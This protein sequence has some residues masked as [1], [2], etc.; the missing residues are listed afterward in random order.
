MTKTRL[1]EF[2]RRRRH[3]QLPCAGG[4]QGMLI[5]R[6]LSIPSLGSHVVSWNETDPRLVSTAP[7]PTQHPLGSTGSPNSP[8]RAL[9]QDSRSAKGRSRQQAQPWVTVT[10]SDS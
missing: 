1:E 9:P 5:P 3:P 10:V 4:K 8:N 2:W 7:A 6:M